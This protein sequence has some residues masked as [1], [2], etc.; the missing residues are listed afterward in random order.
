M[1]TN[2]L[3]ITFL[4]LIIINSVIIFGFSAQ[5]GEESGNLSKL[6][7][8]KI[9]DILNIEENRENFLEVGESI[10]RKLAHFSIYTS[11]GIW[12]ISFILTFKLKLKYQITIASVLGIVYAITDEFH[13]K[14]YE[15]YPNKVS[16]TRQ[17]LQ[18]KLSNIGRYI[19]V[20]NCGFRKK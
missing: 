8:S 20:D 10:V 18:E 13:Q 1:K 15:I 7:I 11:L 14:M 2:I 5:N 12:L 16:A 9:A 19:V 4:I 3:R 6:V 17:E